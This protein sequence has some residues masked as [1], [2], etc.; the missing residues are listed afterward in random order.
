MDNQNIINEVINAV[1]TNNGPM[2]EKIAK[3]NPKHILITIEALHNDIVR[4]TITTLLLSRYLTDIAESS[5]QIDLGL[6][7]ILGKNINNSKEKHV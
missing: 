2:I 6:E 7:N 4:S 1:K 5:R 3:E